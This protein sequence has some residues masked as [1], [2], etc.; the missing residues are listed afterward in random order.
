MQAP[1]LAKHLNFV[2]I[3][4]SVGEGEG[5]DHAARQLQHDRRRFV[6]APF[7]SNEGECLVDFGTGQEPQ[8]IEV[9]NR[10]FDQH[11]PTGGALVSPR[12][13]CIAVMEARRVGGPDNDDSTHRIS[14]KGTPSGSHESVPAQVEPD[15]D[16]PIDPH[17][18][19]N[20]LVDLVEIQGQRLLDKDVLPRIQSGQGRLD[21]E[22]HGYADRH[23]LNARVPQER[24]EVGMHSR[25]TEPLRH[26]ANALNVRV[27]SGD[28]LHVPRTLEDR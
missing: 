21:M 19:R 17:R 11:T 1:S 9:M 8:Q 10:D 25:N 28:D 12:G 6:V 22:L 20:K 16:L 15:H 14:T 7:R 27:G 4:T 13:H 2:G 26:P 5:R 23:R 18:A 3:V 24:P